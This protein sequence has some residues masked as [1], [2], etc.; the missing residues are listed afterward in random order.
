MP[1]K[2]QCIHCQNVVTVADNLKGKT[3]R[4]PFCQEPTKVPG[5]PSAGARPQGRA[6]QTRMAPGQYD[7]VEPMPPPRRPAPRPAPQPHYE[8]EIVDEGAYAPAPPRRRRPEPVY[9]DVP[10]PRRRAHGPGRR[11]M[12]KSGGGLLKVFLILFVVLLVVGGGVALYIFKPDW[13]QWG[14]PA[15]ARFLPG[16][17]N[18]V[19]SVNLASSNNAN[20]KKWTKLAAEY[21]IVEFVPAANLPALEKVL[22]GLDSIIVGSEI[23]EGT[24]KKGIV[25]GSVILQT[26]APVDVDLIKKAFYLSDKNVLND[27]AYRIKEKEVTEKAKSKAKTSKA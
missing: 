16:K 21:A 4:C 20:Y 13:F 24:F 9:D 22:D 10:R 11:P 27:R 14:T 8:E 19:W 18:A 17:T 7:E 15:Y 23:N 1:L 12:R 2:V 6:A 5:G 25:T 26:S 3:I